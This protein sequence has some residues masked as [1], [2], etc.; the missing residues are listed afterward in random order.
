MDELV[1]FGRVTADTKTFHSQMSR[2]LKIKDLGQPAKF[3][4]IELT[5]LRN[6]AVGS[7]RSTLIKNWL[8]AIDTEGGNPMGSPIN[9]DMRD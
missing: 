4:G 5:W 9:P 3:L 7:R 6:K 2:V 1:I 8:K